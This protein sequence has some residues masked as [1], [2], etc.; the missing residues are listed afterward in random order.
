MNK[1]FSNAILAVVCLTVVGAMST[2]A[3]ATTPEGQAQLEADW[4]M[5]CGGKPVTIGI[6]NEISWARDLAGRLAEIK[7]CPSLKAQLDKLAK[8]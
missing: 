2:T 7:G 8:L 5:Q 6:S 3:W 4:L 1:L